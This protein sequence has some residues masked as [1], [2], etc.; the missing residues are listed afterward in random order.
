MHTSQI[1]KIE[2]KEDIDAEIRIN[3]DILPKLCKVQISNLG[4]H[5]R[6]GGRENLSLYFFNDSLLHNYTE[7]FLP[8]TE[9]F[10][11]NGPGVG[12][13]SDTA[14]PREGPYVNHRVES[15]SITV[16]HTIKGRH[17]EIIGHADLRDSSY[18]SEYYKGKKSGFWQFYL[19]I[20]L[21]NVA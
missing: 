17:I 9:K 21:V 11:F 2:M 20:D 5:A 6:F 13:Y 4:L 12:L 15:V 8:I 10:Q 1:W 3:G 14:D 19:I 16:H 18:D 7:D